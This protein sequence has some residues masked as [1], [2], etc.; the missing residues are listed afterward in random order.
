[1]SAAAESKGLVNQVGYHNR[2]L[3]TFTEAKRI[4]ESGALGELYHVQGEAYGPVVL[5]ETGRTW[6]T[7]KGRGGGCLYDYASHV[8]NLLQYIVGSPTHVG[9]VVLDNIY[10]RHVNDA[11]YATLYYGNRMRGQLSVNWSDETYR[12]MSTLVTFLGKTGKIIA[13]ATECKVY[14]RSDSDARDM[15]KGWSIKYLTD[16]TPQVQYYLRGEE[17]TLQIDH[18]I[19]CIMNRSLANRSSFRSAQETD[20]VIEM[21]SNSADGAPVMNSVPK[22]ERAEKPGFWR[23][24][25][26]VLSGA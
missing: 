17:Y 6:R 12:K 15:E 9:G 16:L 26:N 13:D 5:G 22:H 11:V 24:A 3:A 14:L 21:L 7:E 19:E 1:M 4:I 2:F 25:L 10:S 20:L 8:I 18:F 23:R